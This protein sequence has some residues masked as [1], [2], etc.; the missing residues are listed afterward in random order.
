MGARTSQVAL[1]YLPE[2]T[3]GTTPASAGKT[4]RVTSISP[5]FVANSVESEE[6][7]S[8]RTQPR[9]AR[10]EESG[11]LDFGFEFSPRTFDEVLELALHNTWATNTLTN[12]LTRRSAT[13]EL[14]Y[15]GMS[16]A[17]FHAYKGMVCDRLS[18]TIA[19]RQKVTGS[20]SLLGN[21]PTAGTTTAFTGTAVAATTTPIANAV[22]HVTAITEGG[23][24][25]GTVLGLDLE[26]ANNLT[27]DPIVGSADPYDIGL[28]QVAVSGTLRMYFAN[29]TH[30]GKFLANTASA[31]ALE[32][33]VGGD[34][35][36]LTLANI[37][38]TDGNPE[39]PGNNQPVTVPLAFRAFDAGSGT[40]ISIARTL[41]P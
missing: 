13:F 3:R 30:Y 40:V 20:V 33:A 36:A 35:Y 25:L 24:A 34:T 15:G 39:I 32:F 17:V 19:A 1:R 23:S 21:K 7:R 26:V 10:V 5:R 28:G 12:G 6:L 38:Y 22:G 29:A 11:A 14:S 8:T 9:G 31:L 2:V 37:E 16:P 18:L 27:V 41:A 4:L